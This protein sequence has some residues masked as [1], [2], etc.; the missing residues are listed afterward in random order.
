[1]DTTRTPTDE[2]RGLAKSLDDLISEQRK[3]QRQSK[4][5]KKKQ[6]NNERQRRNNSN[7]Q[8]G[9]DRKRR[10]DID[11]ILH[12]KVFRVKQ[13][14][15]HK[16]RYTPRHEQYVSRNQH[17]YRDDQYRGRR[18]LQDSRGRG[19]GRARGRGRGRG[20]QHHDGSMDPEYAG[21]SDP[22][23]EQQEKAALAGLEVRTD[24]SGIQH[25]GTKMIT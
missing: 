5:K 6:T 15:A 16:R 21:H 14:P 9:R 3:T 23:V 4:E 19:R 12:E 7:H 10:D 24:V 1:M 2:P 11:K 17:G 22:A 20:R 13:V 18:E 8:D 25:C